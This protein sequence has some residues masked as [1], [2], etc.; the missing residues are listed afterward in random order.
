[1]MLPFSFEILNLIQRFLAKKN[2]NEC[3]IPIVNKV[4]ICAFAV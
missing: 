3:S 4:L 1:M 2:A